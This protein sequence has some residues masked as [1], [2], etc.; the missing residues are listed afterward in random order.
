MRIGTNFA[1][2]DRQKHIRL[3]I[4]RRTL[5]R[6]ANSEAEGVGK[7]VQRIGKGNEA[8]NVRGSSGLRARKVTSAAGMEV[9]VAGTDQ[10]EDKG[11]QEHGN[12]PRRTVKISG[13][14]RLW[15]I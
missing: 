7:Y 2:I 15:R 12:E 4:Y 11:E 5:G 3:R 14:L 10:R 8:S 9:R 1:Q 13:I 6:R